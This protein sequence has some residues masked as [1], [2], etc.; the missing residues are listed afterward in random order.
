M[1]SQAVASPYGKDAGWNLLSSD[2]LV[3]QAHPNKD[4]AWKASGVF[5]PMS[6]PCIDHTRGQR[7]G[8][9]LQRAEGR[10]PSPTSL[11]VTSAPAVPSVMSAPAAASNAC[12]ISA[13][14]APLFRASPQK[15][16][17]RRPQLA[18]VCV[19]ANREMSKLAMRP[20]VR[21]SG[22]SDASVVPSW[23]RAPDH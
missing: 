23:V 13:M 5:F 3:P 9:L 2:L 11:L 1:V 10:S 21:M 20:T 4:A 7:G 18:P 14:R 15:F 17:C 19:G 22:S 16:T 8:A 12:F 6:S